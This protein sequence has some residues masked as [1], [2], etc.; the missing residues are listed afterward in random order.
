MAFI[1]IDDEDIDIQVPVWA[2]KLI[3]RKE[4]L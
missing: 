3:L 1:F 2:I 4:E